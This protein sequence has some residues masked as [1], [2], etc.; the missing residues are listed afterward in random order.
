MAR[1]RKK[2]PEIEAKQGFPGRRKGKTKAEIEAVARDAPVESAPVRA[3]PAPEW[4]DAEARKLWAVLGEDLVHR[5]VIKSTGEWQ[6]FGRYCD[7]CSTWRKLRDETRTPKGRLKVV[8]TTITAA[9]ASSRTQP[10]TP[11]C[12]SKFGSRTTKTAS[13]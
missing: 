10:S 8:Y 4:L 11:C 1:P 3:P 2:T 12:S 6:E 5:R 7:H 9:S 13:A